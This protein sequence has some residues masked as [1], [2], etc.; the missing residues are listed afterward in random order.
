MYEQLALHIQGVFGVKPET[1][2]EILFDCGSRLAM[3]LR[4]LNIPIEEDRLYWDEFRKLFCDDD[5]RILQ[6]SESHRRDYAAM[7]EA[8]VT[9]LIFEYKLL[10]NL[11]RVTD[12]FDCLNEATCAAANAIEEFAQAAARFQTDSAPS[13]RSKSKKA[14]TGTSDV[15][16]K[17]LI[18]AIGGYLSLKG[19][20]NPGI[21]RIKAVACRA[22]KKDDFN[23]ITAAQLRSLYNA[24][25]KQQ[26]DLRSVQELETENH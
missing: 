2:S 8:V 10:E 21:D 1:R 23:S 22:A 4:E 16:R 15:W 14:P 12:A 24:F 6:N 11:K 3:R 7:K 13:H 17:R 5:V 26:N 20:T 9:D 25:V 19:E 18:A